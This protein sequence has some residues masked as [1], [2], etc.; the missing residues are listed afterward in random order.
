[1][2]L[3]GEILLHIVHKGRDSRTRPASPSPAA[4]RPPP[5]RS[6]R[7]PAPPPP[8]RGSPASSA[9]SP[10]APASAGANCP[11]MDGRNGGVNPVAPPLRALKHLDDV[12]KKGLI[13]NGPKGALVNTGAAGDALSGIDGGLLVRPHGDGVSPCSPAHR[14]ADSFQWPR[15]DRRRDICRR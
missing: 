3:L 6:Y 14:G 8:R 7:R 12:H 10:P 1:M 11:A 13:H 4:R 5:L 2:R 15:K 9:P